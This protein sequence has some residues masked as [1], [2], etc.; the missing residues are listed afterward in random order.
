MDFKGHFA[1]ADGSV[2][3]PLTVLDDHSRFLLGLRACA[4]ERRETV[5]PQLTTLFRTYGLPD[6]MLMDNGSPWGTLENA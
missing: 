3:H 1:L 2:C 6:S 5:Q 4:D